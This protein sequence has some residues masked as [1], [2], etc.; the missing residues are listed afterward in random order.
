VLTAGM[1]FNVSGHT[2][3]DA[4]NFISTVSCYLSVTGLL[5]VL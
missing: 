3:Q 5:C 1:K 2:A 4:R